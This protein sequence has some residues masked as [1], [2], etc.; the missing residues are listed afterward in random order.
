MVPNFF[1]RFPVFFFSFSFFSFSLVFHLFNFF[2][3]L[4]IVPVLC[5]SRRR[6][7]PI[8]F[9]A[10]DA[11]HRSF[12]LW[13]AVLRG[14]TCGQTDL[15]NP[16]DPRLV[17]AFEGLVN[18][19]AAESGGETEVGEL[20]IGIGSNGRKTL[21]S[22][23]LPEEFEKDD[24]ELGHVDFA[25]A[26]A[27][28]RCRVYDLREV[29]RLEVQKVCPYELILDIFQLYHKLFI[30]LIILSLYLPP[31][32]FPLHVSVSV[33]FSFSLSLPLPPSLSLS[34]SHTH[35]HSLS[36]TL[37]HLSSFPFTIYFILIFDCIPLYNIFIQ[38]DCWPHRACLSNYHST[39]CWFSLPRNSQNRH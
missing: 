39:S 26:A 9:D 23:L 33:S 31:P 8:V 15:R 14:R 11:A 10:S 28:L 38:L 7:I 13:A 4:P 21:L 20:L 32:S 12:V 3:S 25:T 5:R 19:K 17:E 36:L 29:D 30:S 34:L 6:P 2:L 35:T 1:F 37:T 24:A 27:N 16:N 18:Q 22:T